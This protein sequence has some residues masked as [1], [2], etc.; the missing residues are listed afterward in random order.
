MKKLFALFMLSVMLSIT[1]NAQSDFK[2]SDYYEVNLT[3]VPGQT[4]PY[5][6]NADL[7]DSGFQYNSDKGYLIDI[8]DNS[9]EYRLMEN[10]MQLLRSYEKINKLNEQKIDALESIIKD[11]CNNPSKKE[12]E[13][14]RELVE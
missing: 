3:N 8:G 10:T 12:I 5:V 2:E 6:I 11:L 14:Y 4:V 7:S 1:V 9:L 13:K